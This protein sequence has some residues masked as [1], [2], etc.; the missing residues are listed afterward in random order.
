MKAKKFTQTQFALKIHFSCLPGNLLKN[1]LKFLAAINISFRSVQVWKMNFSAP[2]WQW[3]MTWRLPILNIYLLVLFDKSAKTRFFS[4]AMQ[5]YFLHF[6]VEA[7]RSTFHAT[8]FNA[9]CL[10]IVRNWMEFSIISTYVLCESLRISQNEDL[11]DLRDFQLLRNSS[12][13]VELLKD[14]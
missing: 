4:T 9:E 14:W 7:L 12:W 5:I 3:K 1:V 13:N 11:R 10:S 8:Y 6:F 2:F